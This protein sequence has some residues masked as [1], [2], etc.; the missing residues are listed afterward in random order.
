MK[1]FQ[2]RTCVPISVVLL[3]PFAVPALAQTA[4]TDFDVTITISS[5]CTIDTPAATNVD[6]GTVPSSTVDAQATGLLNVNC[7]P[8]TTYGVALNEGLNA[9][10][11]GI[12]ARNMINGA[13]LVPYQLYS[14]AARTQVWGLTAGTDTV[15]GTGTGAVQPLTVYGE[16]PSANFPAASY[17]DTI[18]ATISF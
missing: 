13:D 2:L 1:M 8:G 16:V 14:D 4:S 7:T 18:T 12:M 5:T 11:G 10:G 9:G 3:A 6:F 15:A 17:T